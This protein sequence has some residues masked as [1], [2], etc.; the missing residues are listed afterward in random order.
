M[1]ETSMTLQDAALLYVTARGKLEMRRYRSHKAPD[2]GT[3][4]LTDIAVKHL[5][6]SAYR[7]SLLAKIEVH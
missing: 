7:L 1:S 2:C 4:Y 6:C 5:M 3:A